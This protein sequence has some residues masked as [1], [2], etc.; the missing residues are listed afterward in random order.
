MRDATAQEQPTN[1]DAAV[2]PTSGCKIEI[3]QV[4]VHIVPDGTGPDG[5]RVLVL[6]QHR[7]VQ[8]LHVDG[9]AALDVGSAPGRRV[10]A[11]LDGE[12]ASGHPRS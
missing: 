4:A 5:H 10:A 7:R 9:D 2:P 6:A 1:T 3:A 8:K 11:P 12:L